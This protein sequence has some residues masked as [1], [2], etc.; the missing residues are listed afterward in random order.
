MTIT[1]IITFYWY[2]CCCCINTHQSI[3]ITCYTYLFI[4]IQWYIYIY[5]YILI[6]STFCTFYSIFIWF[7]Q[8]TLTSFTFLSTYSYNI[9]VYIHPVRYVNVPSSVAFTTVS[10]AY[11]THWLIVIIW[12]LYCIWSTYRI[13][14][15]IVVL[16][17]ISCNTFTTIFILC[18]FIINIQFI[19]ISYT[20]CCCWCHSFICIHSTNKTIMSIWFSWFGDNTSD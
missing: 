18:W 14:H 7:K 12:W 20:R 10:V 1:I 4:I 19:S 13:H 17:Y 5:M 2:C 15:V 9:Y 6:I 8:S 16:I 11:W 3:C